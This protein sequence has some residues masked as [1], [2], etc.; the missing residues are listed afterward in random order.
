MKKSVL[1]CLVVLAV[2]GPLFAKSYLDVVEM[3]IRVY[4]TP[5]QTARIA[6]D[7]LEFY[8]VGEGSFVGA[9]K[10]PVYDE[11]V[12]EGFKI[13]VL[14]PDVRAAAAK[15]LAAFHTY[16]QIRDT[17]AIIAQNHP[18][19][20]RLD[21]IGN[22]YNGNLMLAMKIS[23]DVNEM[24]GKPRICFDFSIHG[25]ENNG[26]EIALYSII[27][28][29]SGYGTDPD[30]TRWVNDREIWIVPMDNPDGLIARTRENGDGVD[31]NR[32]YGV[33]WDFGSNGGT[34]PFSEPETRSFYRLAEEHPMAAWSQYHS[35]AEIAMWC[36]GW[37]VRAAPDSLITAY[38]MTR[39]GEICGYE[40]GQIPRI[41]Y[42][43]SGGSTDWYQ[44]A[45]GALG[46]AVEV[47]GGQPSPV[48]E[49]DTINHKN[50]SA[51]KEQIERVMWG[52][53]GR[54]LDSVSGQPISARVTVN[55]PNWF[56]YTDS[57]GYYHRNAHEGTYSVTVEANGYR[58][59]TVPGV[60]VQADTFTVANVSLAPDSTAPT[61][62]LKVLTNY[63]NEGSPDLNPTLPRLALGE[64]DGSRY[65]LGNTGYASF[66]MGKNTP[67]V[68]G[69]G[70][71]FSV[72]EGDA[73]AE[74]CSV[75]VSNDW[76]GSW[77]FCGFGTGT[78]SYDIA[79]AGMS[80]ARFVRIVDDGNGGSG[81]YAGFDLDA[82]EA[83]V[84]NAPAMGYQSQTVIDS[85]PGGNSDGR[86]D[87][88]ENADLVVGLRNAGRLSAESLF[89]V[90]RTTDAYVSVS[91]STAF[92]GT[93]PPESV[94]ANFA[95]RF[96]VAAAANT[97]LE[98]LALMRLHL[99]GRGYSDSLPFS[100]TV[101][102]IL[103]TDPIPDGPRTPSLYW[104][105]DDI[106]TL[107]PEHPSYDWVEVNGVGTQMSFTQND[108]VN[109]I[110]IPAAFGPVKL[111]GQR[112][113]QLSVSADGWIACGNYTTS[114]FENTELPSAAAPRATVFAN[115]D[116]LFPETEGSG[117]VYYY[118]DTANHRFVV[119]YDSVAYWSA[120]STRDKFEV[121]YYDTTVTTPS[122]DNA[123]V[124][125]YKTAGHFNSST[126]GIQDPT[127]A[128][129]IQDLYNGSLTHGA[130]PI[131]PGRAIKYTTAPSTGVIEQA[132]GQIPVTRLTLMSVGNPSRGRVA[133][134]YN[135]AV[136]G[137]AAL[138]VYD[139]AGR[140]VRT[141][142]L[143]H[144]PSSL[145]PRPSS[146]VWDGTDAD[147]RTVGAGVY[148]VRLVAGDRS[149][150]AKTTVV[151]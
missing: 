7:V 129:G 30:I 89:A 101:G 88:G 9:V 16:Q 11:L 110:S 135:L 141:W 108:A 151:R 130:A 95:D 149:V 74:A 34:G 82:I 10:K 42:Y 69:P 63:M 125:Q 96:H 44:G 127:R 133:F 20:C 86:L 13:E 90:L 46:Y 27:Q 119:E 87:P 55:P 118:H 122:G 61:C 116:D 113:T 52:I 100:I 45:R 76:N 102:E 146:L 2:V 99:T 28:L 148:L 103:A 132:S 71:D 105:Y 112:Y 126:V 142:D 64:A 48:G 92:Y 79:A 14:V 84:V 124:V 59:K 139:R 75:Y 72:V 60:S 107:Y 8:Q 17:M 39:Y 93:V 5:E 36:W 83:V 145:V 12:A 121:V 47:C 97:P 32:N 31:C 24:R 6:P 26:C 150:V 50:W 114:N 4:A 147:G 144:N 115:W 98:H 138:S 53:S 25:N 134:A 3:K 140:L 37:T 15:D 1:F 57:M 23:D 49:I 91:D 18:D 67:I 51:M 111:Y 136:P 19:I 80:S 94:R 58:T 117:Y 43:V 123:I 29:V 85:P 78:Q 131:A 62:A 128:I 77:T 109:L 137:N 33:A 41:L 56:T 35:G 143:T 22:S 104:A 70:S 120:Q 73:D 106:D 54:V 68:N 65:S 38:E 66:D 81:A 40:A 21:T